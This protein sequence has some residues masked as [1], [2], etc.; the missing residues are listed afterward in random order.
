M[1]RGRPHSLAALTAL[2]VLLDL[3]PSCRTSAS[4]LRLMSILS[5]SCGL[6]GLMDM[7]PLGST[8]GYLPS[9]PGTAGNG[10]RKRENKHRW[11]SR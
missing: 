8:S 5:S 7:R 10:H 3:S 1:N 4:R 2:F 6:R 9:V 11:L